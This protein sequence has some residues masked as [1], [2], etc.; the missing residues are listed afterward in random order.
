MLT[1]IV[2]SAVLAADPVFIE[3]GSCWALGWTARDGATQVV[4]AEK[5]DQRTFR[6]ATGLASLTWYPWIFPG[7][8]GPTPQTPMQECFAEARETCRLNREKVCF[9][10]WIPGFGQNGE[11]GCFV[12]CSVNG[13]CSNPPPIPPVPTFML[14]PENG[15]TLSMI[16]Y[17]AACAVTGDI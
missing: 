17:Q 5:S 15:A 8:S 11:P 13:I 9:V 6:E 1:L 2:A 14:P 3:V 10:Y 7:R 12:G 16:A 4:A